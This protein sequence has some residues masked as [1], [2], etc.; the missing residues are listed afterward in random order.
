MRAHLPHKSIARQSLTKM[1]KITLCVVS[2]FCV[3]ALACGQSA[4][5]VYASYHLYHPEQHNWDLLAES[6]FCSTWY[7]N[8]PLSWRSRYGWTAFCGPVGP[9][10]GAACGKCLRVCTNSLLLI[11]QIK[12]IPKFCSIHENLTSTHFSHKH[13]VHFAT[14]PHSN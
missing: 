7:A 13:I 14:Y 12:Q 11:K 8:Q 10:G 2:L 6:V 3:L 9:H 5:N 1:A 4:T